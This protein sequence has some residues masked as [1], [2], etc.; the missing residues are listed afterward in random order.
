MSQ[1]S[2]N[3]TCPASAIRLYLHT[4]ACN[5]KRVINIMSIGPLFAVM[6]TEQ[7]RAGFKLRPYRTKAAQNSI[8]GVFTRPGSQPDFAVD[9][10]V[11]LNGQLCTVN[12]KSYRDW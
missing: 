8:T 3:I 11:T 6:C 10:A 9:Q 2:R 1:F 5:L 12:G 7:A 4:L